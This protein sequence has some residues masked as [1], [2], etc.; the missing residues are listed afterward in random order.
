MRS[1]IQITSKVPLD[2]L[3]RYILGPI[4]L[5]SGTS[6]KHCKVTYEISRKH[7][8]VPRGGEGKG[9]EGKFAKE[10]RGGEETEERSGGEQRGGRREMSEA[11]P[12]T[13]GPHLPGLRAI[14]FWILEGFKHFYTPL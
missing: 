2:I 7:F 6:S 12:F 9:G 10:R 14:S 11:K 1:L 3:I 4:V 8:T 5:A 13:Q